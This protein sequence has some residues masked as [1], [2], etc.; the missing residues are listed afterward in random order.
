MKIPIVGSI[1]IDS[2]LRKRFFVQNLESLKTVSDLFVWN[3]NIVGRYG[4]DCEREIK[5]RYEQAVITSDN[6]S[7]YY[8]VVKAQLSLPDTGDKDQI[9]FFLQEDHWFVCPHKNLFL[10]L[11]DE[12]RKSSAT[13]L[14]ITHLAEFWRKE[15]AFKVLAENRLYKEYEMNSEGYRNLLHIDPAGYVTSLP[16]IFKKGTANDFLEHNKELLSKQ[17]GSVNFEL[18]GKKAEEFLQNKNLITLAPTFHVLREVFLVNEYDRSMDAKTALAIINTRD[19]PEKKIGAGRKMVNLLAS[20]RSLAGRLKQQI[21][22]I[23]H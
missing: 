14:R 2:P 15:S 20:P 8:Q 13:V 19:N 6:T 22:K 11:L 10:Y 17:K 21:K 23:G 1:K 5:K 7:S 18:Y 12:F 4:Y 16:G 3:F 9:L